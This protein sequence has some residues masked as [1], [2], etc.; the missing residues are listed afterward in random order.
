M[1]KREYRK[2]DECTRTNAVLNPEES[3]LGGGCDGELPWAAAR[4]RPG[5]AG[6]H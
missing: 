5:R 1:S 4:T 6:T 2:R 3:P